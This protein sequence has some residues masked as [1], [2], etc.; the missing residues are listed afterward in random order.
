MV[1]KVGAVVIRHKYQLIHRYFVEMTIPTS[2]DRTLAPNGGHVVHLFTQYTPYTLKKCTWDEATKEQYAKHGD[3]MGALFNNVR[4]FLQ[5]SHK[6]TNTVPASPTAL[7]ATSACRRLSWSAF[8]ASLAAYVACCEVTR[9]NS[10]TE[11]LPR[12]D[13]TQSAVH[14]ATSGKVRQLRLSNGESL[15]LR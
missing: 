4:C 2:V 5:S 8:S 9:R 6:S 11:H 14:T 10:T 15:S 13:D 12:F 3:E 1:E 7:S